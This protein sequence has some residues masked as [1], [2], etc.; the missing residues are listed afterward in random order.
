M[1]R[2]LGISLFM[3]LA[4]SAASAAAP[5]CS[6]LFPVDI[7]GM[8]IFQKGSGPQMAYRESG[9]ISA[10]NVIVF[11]NGIDKDSHEWDGVRDRLMTK[12]VSAHYLQL[13]LIGQGETAKLNSQV[14]EIPYQEQIK[15]L[16]DFLASKNLNGKNLILIGHSYGGGIAARYIHDNPGAVKSAVLINPFVDNLEFHQPVVGP[17]MAWTQFFSAMS[18]LGG[19]YEAQLQLSA[20]MAALATWPVYNYLDRAKADLPHILSLTYGIRNLGMTAAVS[21]PGSTRMNL[22]ISGLDELIPT[23]AHMQLWAHVPEANRGLFQRLPLTHES[24]VQAPDQITEAIAKA[25]GL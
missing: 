14:Q 10:Q 12:K 5:I 25:L 6:S 8:Q 24:V 3:S 19:L 2:H 17:M 20:D 13:D 15:L 23:E 7:G 11:L 22:V 1:I 18:G 21:N 16:Q 4:V 9:D